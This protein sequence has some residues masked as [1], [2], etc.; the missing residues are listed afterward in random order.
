[1]QGY[2]LTY[3]CLQ[4]ENIRPNSGLSAVENFISAPTALQCGIPPKKDPKSYAFT[5]N[6]NESIHNISNMKMAHT[7]SVNHVNNLHNGNSFETEQQ[8]PLTT[9]TTKPTKKSP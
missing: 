1:M 7:Q 6:T 5:M 8:G 2:I 4:S 9:A 3:S